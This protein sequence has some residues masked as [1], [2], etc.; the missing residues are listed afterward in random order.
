MPICPH[1]AVLVIEG[2]AI[3]PN[4]VIPDLTS[5]RKC[6]ECFV[7]LVTASSCFVE[8]CNYCRYIIGGSLTVNVKDGF[9]YVKLNFKEKVIN[10]IDFTS[11]ISFYRH[12]LKNAL[13]NVEVEPEKLQL[14]KD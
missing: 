11:D 6:A 2:W 10:I 12:G 7:L 4:S 13:Q 3:T 8:P 14:R 5:Q 1:P 9:C